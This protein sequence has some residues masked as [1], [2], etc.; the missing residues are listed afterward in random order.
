MVAEFAAQG[1]QALCQSP[2]DR[3]NTYLFGEESSSVGGTD[4]FTAWPDSNTTRGAAPGLTLDRLEQILITEARDGLPGNF[5]EDFQAWEQKLKTLDSSSLERV[6]QMQTLCRMGLSREASYHWY[7]FCNK[8]WEDNAN[9]EH[10]QYCKACVHWKSHWR[11]DVCKKC[12][13][14]LYAP[15]G[16]CGDKSAV[17]AA[18]FK[19][20]V[21]NRERG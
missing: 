10:C 6:A 1:A 8:T 15:C 2:F 19:A 7:S 3:S 9:W 18:E 5:S 16:G 20:G 13:N 14:H 12:V 17:F 21:R 4:C 11:Y